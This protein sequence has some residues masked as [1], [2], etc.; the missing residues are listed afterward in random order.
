M[1]AAGVDRGKA[2]CALIASGKTIA[3]RRRINN[4]QM[5]APLL[6]VIAARCGRRDRRPGA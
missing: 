6:A 2:A 5:G 4:V 1:A 3:S